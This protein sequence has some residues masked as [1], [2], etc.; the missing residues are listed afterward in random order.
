MVKFSVETYFWGG[1]SNS[2]Y[3]AASHHHIV[4]YFPITALPKA[5]FIPY[6]GK[7]LHTVTIM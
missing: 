7:M 5:C 1:N 6:L 2:T 4:G 3:W